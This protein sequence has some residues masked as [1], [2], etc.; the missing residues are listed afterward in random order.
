[1]LVTILVGAA[2]R[3]MQLQR[4]QERRKR[5]KAQCENADQESYG[6]RFLHPYPKK[7]SVCYRWLLL[8]SSVL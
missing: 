1:M 2:E 6:K 3:M 8:R 7:V 5:H 4:R